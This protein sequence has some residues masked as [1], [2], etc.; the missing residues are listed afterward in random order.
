M[1]NLFDFEEPQ[2]KE[3]KMVV[4]D[5]ILILEEMEIKVSNSPLVQKALRVIYDRCGRS[6]SFQRSEVEMISNVAGDWMTTAID[7]AVEAEW[8]IQMPDGSFK[9]KLKL[10]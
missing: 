3:K 5:P 9:T 6:K 4:R 8:C 2:A 10:R 7:L 1:E